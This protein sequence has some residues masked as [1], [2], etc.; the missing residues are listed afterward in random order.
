[1]TTEV[2]NNVKDQTR[3]ERER[4]PTP[5]AR[6]GLPPVSALRRM[7]AADFGVRFDAGAE[8]VQTEALQAVIDLAGS[9]GGAT[10]MLSPGRVVTGTLRL[11]SG[12]RLYLEEG[13]VLSGS[14]D[15]AD[16]AVG[17]GAF[18]D[19]V[20]Q[21]RGRA[22]VLAEDCEDVGLAGAGVIDGNG[23]S[24]REG[25]AYLGRPFLVRFVGCRNVG[26]TGVTL[27]N[28]A[29]WTLHLLRC[30]QVNIA[31]V[32]IDSRVNQNNDGIDVD[33]SRGVSIVDCD[34][35][36]DD[37]AI[38][39]KA[40][41]AEPCE[42]V[43]VER[44]RLW[45]GC[46]AIK[47]GTETYGDIRRVKVRRCVVEHAGLGALKVISMDGG[48]VE[49]VEVS[50]LRVL[51][52]AGPVF[53]RL[54]ARGKTY[55]AGTAPKL[56]GAIRRVRV[57]DLVAEVTVPADGGSDYFTG[58][59]FPA[60]AFSGVLVTGIEGHPVSG[61]TFER[62][63]IKFAGGGEAGDVGRRVPE[64]PSAYPELFYFGVLPAW[65]FYFR[66]AREVTLIDVAA[67]AKGHDPRPALHREDVNGFHTRGCGP[68]MTHGIRPR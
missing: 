24:F 11:R 31:G 63:Q 62:V 38:C 33:S 3:A 2:S 49:D 20:G 4:V 15:P 39:L 25:E 61:L 50:G 13:A 17:G 19:A 34:V 5:D 6:G 32:T 65:A 57:T 53:I 67:T 22:L 55:G 60:R 47:I 46:G 10:V 14:T 26:V 42:D 66:H 58:E 52:G 23:A 41:S 28:S 43:V 44:C 9:L 36:T 29:A 59:R 35:R 64:Q 30:R 54:G 8:V 1:M 18:V 48:T 40:T 68:E 56:A 27:R 16:Y 7:Y 45:S 12:V 21:P 37:D 51:S